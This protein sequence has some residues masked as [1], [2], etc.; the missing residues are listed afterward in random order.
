MLSKAIKLAKGT[1][2]PKIGLSVQVP[3]SLKDEFENICKDNNVSMSSMLLSLIQVA[4]E[5]S[6]ENNEPNTV[7]DIS[8]TL[9]ELKRKRTELIEEIDITGEEVVNTSNGR[10]YLGEEIKSL[11][12]HIK[13]LEQKL[14]ELVNKG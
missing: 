6:K 4:I 9:L 13:D 7:L 3:K 12:L 5:E 1:E 2:E 14:N 10:R 8:N 11:S